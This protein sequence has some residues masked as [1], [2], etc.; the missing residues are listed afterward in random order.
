M[1]EAIDMEHFP[2]IQALTPYPGPQEMAEGWKKQW[3]PSEKEKCQNCHSKQVRKGSKAQTS[4]H[5][6]VALPRKARKPTMTTF[7]GTAQRTLFTNVRRNVLVRREHAS[8]TPWGLSSVGQPGN[9]AHI[10]RHIYL[11]YQ[12]TQ[13]DLTS[14]LCSS[15]RRR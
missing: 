9:T 2:R 4:S 6:R 8:E 10:P 14:G 5:A 11:V 12:V 7:H 13:K 1:G 3:P 15:F